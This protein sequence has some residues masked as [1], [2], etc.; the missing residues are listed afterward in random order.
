MILCEDNLSSLLLL[1]SI[2][3][4]LPGKSGSNLYIQ[5]E[6]SSVQKRGRCYG[7]I[8]GRE[9]ALLASGCYLYFCDALSFFNWEGV[10]MIKAD[11]WDKLIK[12]IMGLLLILTLILLIKLI[13]GGG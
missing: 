10:Q 7:S 5:R 8:E 6:V 1:F 9:C 12:I 2:L 11:Y 13:F 3:K 4:N